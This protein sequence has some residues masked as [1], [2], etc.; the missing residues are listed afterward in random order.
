ME[1]DANKVPSNYFDKNF[2][3]KFFSLN[4]AKFIGFIRD[5]ISNEN[6]TTTEKNILLASLLYSMQLLTTVG[7]YLSCFRGCRKESRACRK[8]AVRRKK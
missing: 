8:G 5:K 4:D 7:D 3:G 1:L 6:C 2:G